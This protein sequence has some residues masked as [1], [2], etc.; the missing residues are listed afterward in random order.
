MAVVGWGSRRQRT[1]VRHPHVW[2]CCVVPTPCLRVGDVWVACCVVATFAFVSTLV[3]LRVR[4]CVVSVRAA[5]TFCRSSTQFRVTDWNLSCESAA[6]E[7]WHGLSL[8]RSVARSS[9]TRHPFFRTRDNMACAAPLGCFEMPAS[10]PSWC[11]D[12]VVLMVWCHATELLRAVAPA[13]GHF[14][15]LSGVLQ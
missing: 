4:R 8:V 11:A 13:L 5:A 14:P 6:D 9:V 2:P 1:C 7:G 3:P 12:V 10:C 15:S